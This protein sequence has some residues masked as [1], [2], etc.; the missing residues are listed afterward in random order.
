MY[1]KVTH[2]ILLFTTLLLLSA[3]NKED[4]ANT[5]AKPVTISEISNITDLTATLSGNAQMNDGTTITAKGFVWEIS[6]NPV[7]EYSDFTNE[8]NGSGNFTSNISHLSRD[9]EYFVRAYITTSEET[10]Y[11]EERTFRT[12]NQCVGGVFKGYIELFT[13]DM[14]NEFGSNQ[15]CEITGKLR[16]YSYGNTPH[17]TDLS[18]L[19]SI[20]KVGSLTI[21][22]NL[23]LT[24]L[25]GLNIIDTPRLVIID[26]AALE[27]IDALS[28]ITTPITAMNI[29]YNEE[30]QDLDGLSG[31]TQ[32]DAEIIALEL[33]DNPSLTNIDG[34]S[35]VTSIKGR[36]E[37][38]YNDLLQ[39]LNGFE[40]VVSLDG[41]L[42][43]NNN[44]SL[45]TI[46]GFSNVERLEN[47][48]II[49]NPELIIID[50]LQ[51]LR[52][53]DKSIS[54]FSNG[55]ITSLSALSSLE[56]VGES[57]LLLFSND[58]QTLDGL[59]NLVAVRSIDIGSNELLSDFCALE[60]LIANGTKLEEYFVQGNAYNPTQQDI[61]DGNC[62]L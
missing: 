46:N 50:D 58:L 47:L 23:E 24:S 48:K 43:I 4:D 32:L 30:L 60:N 35:N 59:E 9:T 17:I 42:D 5:G 40:N 13:Q 11:S 15:Y 25:D 6:P 37:I 49:Y 36:V 45:T 26:N 61:L 44:T 55:P 39:N 16:I 62:S 12:T 51:S 33:R 3:C 34:L 2:Y 38:S 19:Y 52:T 21:D 14:V 10:I 8:G 7:I 57:F 20:K 22:H 28:T 29:S 54:I 53:V 1:N 27:N 18:P 31:L 56:T 41:P